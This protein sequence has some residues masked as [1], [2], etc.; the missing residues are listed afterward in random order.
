MLKIEKVKISDGGFG[1]A[2]GKGVAGVDSLDEVEAELC[3]NLLGELASETDGV[4]SWEHR[5]HEAVSSSWV[6]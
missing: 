5:V 6:G 4:L 1:V 3:L 2:D